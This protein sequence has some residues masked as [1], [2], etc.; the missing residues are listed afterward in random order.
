MTAKNLPLSSD[1]ML[2]LAA[3]LPTP[4]HLYDG[5]AIERNAEE[6]KSAFSWAPEFVNFF[7][8]KALPNVNILRLLAKHGFGA[9][10]SSLPE[11]LM[12]EEAGI[13]GNKIMFTSNDTPDEEFRKAFELGAILNLDDITHIEA[14]KRACGRLPETI[15]FRFNPGPERTGN[16]II[17]N[18]VEAKYGVT[19]AQLFDC[20]RIAKEEGVKKFYLHTM[21]AS[22]ELTGDYIVETARMLFSL[23]AEIK[24]RTGVEIEAVDLGGGVGIPYKEE[25]NRIEWS[26]LGSEIGK[27]YE[28]MIV[29]KGLKPLLVSFECGRVIT[30]PYGYLVTKVRHVTEKYKN[31]VGVDACMADL[32]RPALYGSYHHITVLGKENDAKDHVYDVTGSLCENNDKFA[33][34][35]PLP[36]ISVGDVL[37]IHDT[38]A[39]GFAMGF[40]YNGK[41]RHAEYLLSEGKVL[42]IR[43]EE[44]YE[45][46]MR[47]QLF[48]PEE[49]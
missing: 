31:Y 16:A 20:Y 21:V 11:L 24:E 14:V 3:K 30:G 32:M 34:D 36:A 45:D 35:R 38:G 9:D 48:S 4:F 49:V 2:A 47:T 15:S 5:D 12:A 6:M 23:V 37:V 22:N 40:N 18:P 19:R 8:V 33:I 25:Q 10:C 44:T 7:A 42:K 13:S 29:N 17:G 39:H 46:Y 28:E 41:M 27:L 1:K 26:Y 43:R